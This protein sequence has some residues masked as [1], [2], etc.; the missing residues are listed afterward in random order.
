MVLN[1]TNVRLS[2]S[3]DVSIVYIFF[4]LSVLISF[5]LSFFII[6]SIIFTKTFL[7]PINILIYNTCITTFFYLIMSIL[8]ISAFYNGFVLS[9][10]WC[11]IQAY[12]SYVC[13]D[14]MMYS[15]VI[16]AISRLFFTI[17]YQYKYLLN[18]K[19]HLILIICQIFLSFLIPLPSIITE[20]IQFLPL[21]MCV[22]PMRNL[23][24]ILYLHTLSYFTPFIVVA[25]IYIVIL[26][27]GIQSS[28]KF[29]RSGHQ[30]RRDVEL[31]RTI[32]IVFTIFIFSA[33]PNM[34]YI[35]LSIQNLSTSNIF[36]IFAAA[37]S[38]ISTAFE[39]LSVIILNKNIR[40]VIKNR[41]R[42]LCYI[43]RLNSNRI[44]PFTLSKNR[45]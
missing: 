27:R 21:K 26:R 22:I 44:Q 11:Q 36:Y 37:A 42:K 24:E 5:L 19:C 12:L 2:S 41:W 33:L 25:S 1:T 17:F 43:L 7:S 10:S 32:L 31:L 20:D 13:L 16:Q 18:Y 9:D 45:Y 40:K 30:I 29:H 3:I 38:P 39:K 8:K 14:L 28:L 6:I 15:Y 34:V 23:F 4:V 35:A